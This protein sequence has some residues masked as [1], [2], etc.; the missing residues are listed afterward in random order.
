[1]TTPAKPTMTTQE[2]VD[3]YHARLAEMAT[4]HTP[5]PWTVEPGEVTWIEREDGGHRHLSI[6]GP[7]FHV[8]LA[9]VDEDDDEQAANAR[10]IAAA[11]ELLAALETTLRMLAAMPAGTTSRAYAD[12]CALVRKAKGE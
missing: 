6:G 4:Q 10:L 7:E 9:Q 12:A 5:G 1:M 3:A 8:G 11:P 2:K